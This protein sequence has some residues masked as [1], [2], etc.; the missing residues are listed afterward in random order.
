MYLLQIELF[1]M[2]QNTTT[3][4]HITITQRSYGR[5]SMPSARYNITL[6]K[7][8]QINESSTLTN[9]VVNNGRVT[10]TQQN[11]EYGWLHNREE[12]GVVD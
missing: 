4:S 10:M 7:L 9:E 11:R 2:I 6:L 12:R 8:T 1:V 5:L 3:I